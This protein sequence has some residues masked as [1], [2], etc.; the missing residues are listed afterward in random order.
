M[1]MR[2]AKPVVHGEGA[3]TV[4]KCGWPKNEWPICTV[5]DG[6]IHLPTCTSRMRKDIDCCPARH[7]MLHDAG[8]V[9]GISDASFFMWSPEHPGGYHP[10]DLKG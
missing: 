6:R 1:S 8:Q 5:C 9:R 10:H 4:S 7:K 3:Q 2:K